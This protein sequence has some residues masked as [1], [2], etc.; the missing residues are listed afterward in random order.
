MLK[1][2]FIKEGTYKGY[3]Y[4]VILYHPD[5][6]EAIRIIHYCGYVQIPE[7]HPYYKVVKNHRSRIAYGQKMYDAYDKLDIDCH[8]GLTFSRYVN[9]RNRNDFITKF[10]DGVWVGWDYAHAGDMIDY[11]DVSVS[12]WGRLWKQEDVI[13]ECKD[14][15]DQ[16][17]IKNKK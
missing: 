16:L 11:V 12:R 6:N 9:K 17:I 5:L 2:K 15:I 10:E 3:K 14:V 7:D 4:K 1:N 8:G 13:E